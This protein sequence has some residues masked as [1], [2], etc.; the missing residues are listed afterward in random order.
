MKSAEKLLDDELKNGNSPSIQ[1]HIFT[2]D[3]DL[4]AYKKGFA[5]IANGRKVDFNTTYNA[6]SIT[7]TFTALTILQLEEKG[8]IKIEMRVNHYL[9][10]FLYG[11]EITIKQLLNHTAG[12]PNPI[13]L[14][15]IHLDTEHPN[16]NRNQFFKA[17]F[18]KHSKVKSKPNEKMAYSN[19]GYVVLGQLIE[20][21]TGK[22]YEA[23]VSE[24]IIE[25][26]PIQGEYLRFSIANYEHQ[27]KGYHKIASFSNFILGFFINKSKFMGEKEDKWRPFKTYYVNGAPYGGLIGTPLAFATYLKELLKDKSD[28]ISRKYKALLFQENQNIKGKNTGMCLGWFTGELNGVKYFTH[29]GGG[30][31]YYCEIRIYPQIKLGSVIFFNRTGMSDER[32]LDKIDTFFLPQ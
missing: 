30:G 8:E 13:P 18:K 24:Y 1:Y 17:I 4:Y 6:F 32:F 9:P 28:L 19:L 5:D 22:S 31:G 29:A 27:A 2:S 21:V 16:F 23:Y 26:L 20:K 10:D 25:K 12:L 15:W 7:K 11:T 3:S 14:N